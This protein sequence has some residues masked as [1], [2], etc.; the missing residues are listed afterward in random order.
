M[1]ISIKKQLLTINVIAGLLLIPFPILFIGSI[2]L[3]DA[4]G[5]TDSIATNSIYYS[6]ITYPITF[7]FSVIATWLGY[8]RGKNQFAWYMSLLP[9]LNV[10]TFFMAI[11]FIILVCEG[12]FVCY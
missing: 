7:L 8:K 4:P 6:I 9:F 11:A 5:S 1:K 10:I 2:I 12:S 3:F